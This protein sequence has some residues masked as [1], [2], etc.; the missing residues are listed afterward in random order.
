MLKLRISTE[1]DE[2]LQLNRVTA[3]LIHIRMPHAYLKFVLGYMRKDQTLF[4]FFPLE[5]F[6]LGEVI[7][8][9]EALLIL[10][11]SSFNFQV[12]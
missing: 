3:T 6:Y 1:E 8:E 4:A 12:N 7:I 11:L 5:T 9:F 10:H 2:Q